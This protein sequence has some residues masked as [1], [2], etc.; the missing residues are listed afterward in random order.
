ML[1]K[2]KWKHAKKIGLVDK[3]NSKYYSHNENAKLHSPIRK[4]LNENAFAQ[5]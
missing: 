1:T 4:F 3:K 5:I 2:C